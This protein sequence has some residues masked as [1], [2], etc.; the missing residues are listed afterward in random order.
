M[1]LGVNS[2]IIFYD[3]ETFGDYN[4]LWRYKAAT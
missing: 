2:L 3:K 1:P 4:I